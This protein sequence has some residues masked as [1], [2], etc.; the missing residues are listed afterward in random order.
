MTTKNTRRGFLKKAVAASALTAG[1]CGSALDIFRKTRLREMDRVEL[2]NFL[3]DLE[4]D[5][6]RKFGEEVG[7]LHHPRRPLEVHATPPREGVVFG[8]GL[9]LSRCN[10]NRKCVTA[11]V[12]EN[13]Q[14][15]VIA[16]SE[17][18]NPIHWITVLEMDKGE[19]VD[20]EHANAYYNPKKVP[21]KG[22]FYVPVQ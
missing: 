9:D 4:E 20:F 12:K 7:G 5:Y 22:K 15:R 8:Y 6:A 14:S 2:R 1:G 10:G 11:C 18:A 21:Q 17:H 13:N 3:K 19:G 16:D